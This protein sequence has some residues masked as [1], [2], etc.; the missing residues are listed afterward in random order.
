MDQQMCD[1]LTTGRT[2]GDTNLLLL[3]YVVLIQRQQQVQGRGL[4]GTES[5]DRF[6]SCENGTAYLVVTA[7][8]HLE[9]L[10][11]SAR[12]AVSAIS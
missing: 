6:R 12:R 10:A 4:T 5:V 3:K 2:R 8:S 9:C 7:Q 1:L 11:S